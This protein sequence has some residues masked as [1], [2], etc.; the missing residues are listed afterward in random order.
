MA[1]AVGAKP[2]YDFADKW[3]DLSEEEEP[4]WALVCRKAAGENVRIFAL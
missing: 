4:S 3:L 2:T 1:W